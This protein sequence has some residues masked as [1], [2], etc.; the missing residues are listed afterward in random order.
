MNQPPPPDTPSRLACKQDWQGWEVTLRQPLSHSTAATARVPKL[1]QAAIVPVGR[2]QLFLKTSRR[3][4]RK[5]C[6]LWLQG[7]GGGMTAPQV[8]LRAR[9]KA[10]PCSQMHNLSL[11]EHSSHYWIF[12]GMKRKS[13]KRRRR[14]Q[15]F[16]NHRKVSNAAPFPPPS[17]HTTLAQR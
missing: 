15:S 9:G 4:S 6:R 1:E 3:P 7:G 11:K 2:L 8:S 13:F 10:A 12:S 14:C 16:T 17:P 5:P